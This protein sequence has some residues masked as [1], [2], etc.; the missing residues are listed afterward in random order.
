MIKSDFF[1]DH[2]YCTA[3]NQINE[4]QGVNPTKWALIESLLSSASCMKYR[5]ELLAC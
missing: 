5:V 3:D 1:S 2:L 4:W